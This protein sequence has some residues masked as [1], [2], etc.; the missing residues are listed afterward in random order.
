V[1]NGSVELVAIAAAPSAVW[2]ALRNF[3]LHSTALV[4]YD[5][6]T[7]RPGASL[8][9][10]TLSGF[11]DYYPTSLL[12]SG[13]S[14]W[15]AS[16]E[17]TVLR[18]TAGRVTARV[19]FPDLTTALLA[20]STGVWVAEVRHGKVDHI[21]AASG[22]VDRTIQVAGSNLGTE[23]VH[24]PRTTLSALPGQ[25]WVTDYKTGAAYRVT[26]P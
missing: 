3:N 18:I 14:L 25:L 11:S 1:H 10:S 20:D 4:S 24:I 13:G 9:L 6:R 17:G 8:D 5:P 16:V 7:L 23:P 21:S 26:L 12:A 2:A 22:K 15:V 19:D